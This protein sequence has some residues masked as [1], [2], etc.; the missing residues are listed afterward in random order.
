MFNYECL[1][2]C[3]DEEAESQESA[4][5]GETPGTMELSTP[6]S[7]I[8]TIETPSRETPARETEVETDSSKATRKTKSEL[9][10]SKSAGDR[11]T[12]VVK[13][14]SHLEVA[15]IPRRSNSPIS[16]RLSFMDEG[17]AKTSRMSNITGGTENMVFG[18]EAVIEREKINTE[19]RNTFAVMDARYQ[20]MVNDLIELDNAFELGLM[21]GDREE[22]EKR[23]Q[24][25]RI[26][27][28][29]PKRPQDLPRIELTF[30][31]AISFDKEEEVKSRSDEGERT[32]NLAKEDSQDISTEQTSTEN[33]IDTGAV[34]QVN[35]QK[36]D[37][38]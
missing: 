13:F 24:N 11:P 37:E 33:M 32:E 28:T 29:P 12:S 10:R 30:D 9:V 19:A 5:P 1:F 21:N 16:S 23:I 36:S 7:Q 34:D 31:E 3:Q 6:G 4:S 26:I 15:D 18:R 38:A 35:M 14:A 2:L 20:D 22:F 27:K 25:V 17:T 8:P